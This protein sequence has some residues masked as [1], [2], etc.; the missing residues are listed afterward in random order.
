ML[1]TSPGTSPEGVMHGAMKL[2][3]NGAM[4]PAPS[5]SP[6]T[7]ALRMARQSWRQLYSDSHACVAAAEQAFQRGVQRGDAGGR[8]LGAADARLPHDLVCHAAR[9]RAGAE[10]GAALLRGGA[11]QGRAAAGRSRPG[12]LRLARRPL[13]GVAGAGLAAARRRPAHPRARRARHAAQHHRRLLLR[14]GPVAAGL[15]LHVPGAA[16]DE[17][18]QESRLR[19]GAVLQP[20]ARADPA[21]RLPP[22]AELPA[23]RAGALPAG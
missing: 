23:R 20:G 6:S 2:T 22:G 16:R 9:S 21:G 11:R 15:C 12:A 17:S 10:P 13:P 14:A 8:G 1:A 3:D 7:A 18:R 4:S 19:R 5:R